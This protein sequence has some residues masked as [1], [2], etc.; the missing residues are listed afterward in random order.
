MVKK[1]NKKKMS[2]KLARQSNQ[3][4]GMTYT[5]DIQKSRD[6]NSR[7]DDPLTTRNYFC[8]PH[9]KF[10]LCTISQFPEDLIGASDACHL[11]IFH[12]VLATENCVLFRCKY[13]ILGSLRCFISPNY[14]D[15]L[16]RWATSIYN[17]VKSKIF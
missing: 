1:I 8:C 16:Q 5:D 4:D 12:S 14:F 9:N 3:Q 15:S 17:S 13:N 7:V 10:F 2:W 11:W 6:T